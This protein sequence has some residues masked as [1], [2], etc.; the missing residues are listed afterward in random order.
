MLDDVAADH[1]VVDYHDINR[2]GLGAGI[3]HMVD[4]G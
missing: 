4:L 2:C 1:F 3:N